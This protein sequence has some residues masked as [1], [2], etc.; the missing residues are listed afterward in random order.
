LVRLHPQLEM[1]E[2][3]EHTMS[4]KSKSKAKSN[5]KAKKATPTP[6]VQPQPLSTRLPL[7]HGVVLDEGAVA[8]M[9][10]TDEEV[11]TFWEARR[12]EFNYCAHGCAVK[13]EVDNLLEEGEWVFGPTKSSVIRA[14]SRWDAV[15]IRVEWYDWAG[16]VNG[17]WPTFA[18]WMEDQVVDRT[19]ALREGTWSAENEHAFQNP[20]T[21]WWEL[22]DTPPGF[23]DVREALMFEDVSDLADGAMSSA[24]VGTLFRE[25]AFDHWFDHGTYNVYCMEVEDI[26]EW[27][28]GDDDDCDPI[29]PSEYD[30]MVDSVW[31]DLLTVK[32]SPASVHHSAPGQP[33]DAG[34]PGAR[35]RP[36]AKV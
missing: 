5:P 12:S 20:V 26:G 14:L 2:M 35:I 10:V 36:V 1:N 22:R 6:K 25:K 23:P 31:G 32:S 33:P 3:Q 9:L 29:D 16:D 28:A 30:H 15:G 7:P 18:E 11:R 21:A 8:V 27:L 4:A 24:D 19:T 13:G 17:A 34:S